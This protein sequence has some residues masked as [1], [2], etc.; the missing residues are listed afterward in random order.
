MKE[1]YN[2]Y[3]PESF[4]FRIFY[5]RKHFHSFAN[6]ALSSLDNRYRMRSELLSQF[7][8]AYKGQRC[9]IMGNGPSLNKMDLSL[10]GNDF[11][12]G[13]NRCYLLFE[14]I[15]W[16]PIF[17]TAVDKRVVPDNRNDINSLVNQLT[18]T[19]FFFPSDFKIN[20]ILSSKKNVFWFDE[21]PYKEGGSPRD[22]FSLNPSIW[23][24]AVR[25]VT[26]TALQLAVYL[27]FNPIY[28]IGCDTSYS[29]PPTVR[30]ENGN[31]NFIIST[32]DDPNH[33]DKS[34]FGRDK[35]WHDTHVDRMIRHYME[36]KEVCDEVGVEI[37]N[38]TVGGEL[39]V[40]PR[41]NYLDLF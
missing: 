9:F 33:F 22:N 35:K 6:M 13:T 37:V 16:R 26:I 15:S 5:Y 4:R 1:F 30:Y 29:I 21:S 12:W 3:F 28:L 34:Y 18:D 41:V 24:S 11:I 31:P 19:C 25:T 2:S 38:A 14:R 23:V 39:E 7:K 27:G 32:E 10:F 40:F 17:Y 36:V 8:D 20:K